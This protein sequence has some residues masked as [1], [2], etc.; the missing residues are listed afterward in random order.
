MPAKSRNRCKLSLFRFH[1]SEKSTVQYI[2]AEDGLN[3]PL[4]VR[5]LDLEPNYLNF[6]SSDKFPLEGQSRPPPPP[7][8][9]P[10]RRAATVVSFE[11]LLYFKL[12]LQILDLL[13]SRRVA[14]LQT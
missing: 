1:Y 6:L 14:L 10:M 5:H 9:S 7:P 3:C 8:P 2:S 11:A 13:Y 4:Q 12:I